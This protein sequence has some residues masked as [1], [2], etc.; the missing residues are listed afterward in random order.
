[1]LI[2]WYRRLLQ[3]VNGS[4]QNQ[5]SG[6]LVDAE[7][8]DNGLELVDG[9]GDA[10]RRVDGHVTRTWRHAIAFMKMM[11][12]THGKHGAHSTEEFLN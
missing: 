5:R 12:P 8:E 7:G 4:F 2:N 3:D 10:A 1:M 11:T 9:E 6:L